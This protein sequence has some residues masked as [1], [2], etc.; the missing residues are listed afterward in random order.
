M[1]VILGHAIVILILAVI[2][3]FCGRSVIREIRHELNGGGC[4]GCGGNCSGCTA[5]CHKTDPKV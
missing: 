4:S 3:F 2:V 5:S 1:S